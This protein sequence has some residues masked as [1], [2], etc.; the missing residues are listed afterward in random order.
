MPKIKMLGSKKKAITKHYPTASRV[1]I[2]QEY[3]ITPL[4]N[5]QQSLTTTESQPSYFA[6]SF[7]PSGIAL[8]KS[9]FH[10]TGR[11]LPFS[12]SSKNKVDISY[13][14]L[15]ETIITQERKI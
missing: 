9:Y 2:K 12:D 4:L 1:C 11:S 7:F 5:Q 8:E 6:P 10:T 13:P 3:W 15:V 14:S